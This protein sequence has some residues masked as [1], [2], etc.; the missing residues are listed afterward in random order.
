MRILLRIALAAL[1]TL[2]MFLLLARTDAIPAWLYSENGYAA[3]QPL[4]PVFGA[5]GVDGDASVV[6]G[7]LLVASFVLSALVVSTLASVFSRGRAG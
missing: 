3:L 6:T 2:P 4:F 1:L 5:V 7:V